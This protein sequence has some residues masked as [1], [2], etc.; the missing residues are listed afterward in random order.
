MDKHKNYYKIL[1]V[2][3]K[4]SAKEIKTSYYKISMDA[5]PDKGGDENIFKEITEAYK[6]LSSDKKSEYDLKSKYGKNYDE[7]SEYL[8]F[9]FNNE[10]KNYDKEAYDKW[11]DREQLNII[12]HI[13]EN[14][15]G[16]IEYQRYVM[17][18]ACDG[19][20]KDN[21]SRIMIKNDKGEVKYFDAIDGCDF[22]EGTG[23][24]GELDCLY[25]FGA[26]KVGAK[27]CLTCNGEKR[28]LGKQKL[29]GIS[30]KEG[31]KDHKVEFMGHVSKDIPGKVGDLWLVKKEQ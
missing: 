17:C 18:K 31:S 27:R 14:F 4:A 21:S 16:K 3:N 25:C 11:K 28:I 24:W 29:S 19:S 7:L 30:I 12:V 5:H 20:G 6:I 2:T 15:N 1:G 23:K 8:D 10:A 9:E 22:C 13:D 26:G